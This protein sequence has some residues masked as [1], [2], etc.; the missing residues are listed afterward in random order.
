MKT[1]F[2][3]KG[4]WAAVLTLVVLFPSCKKDDDPTRMELLTDK[5]WKLTAQVINPPIPAENGTLVTDLYAQYDACNKD[6]LATFRDSGNVLFDEGPSKCMNTD[7][8]TV[9]GTWAF[10]TTETILS[11]T[12]SNETSSWDII[13]LEDSKLVVEE[14]FTDL[15]ITYTITSTYAKQ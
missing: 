8:Q 11:I 14:E 3:M 4:L 9:T 1:I 5:A 6:D 12:L 7:P 2:Q 13:T 10:N 15:G